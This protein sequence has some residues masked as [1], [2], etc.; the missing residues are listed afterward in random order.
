MRFSILYT[1]GP[2]ADAEGN[3]CELHSVTVTPYGDEG[4]ILKV[5]QS[6]TLMGVLLSLASFQF[7]LMKSHYVEYA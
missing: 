3:L 5:I 4:K 2:A 7:E 6:D 1:V